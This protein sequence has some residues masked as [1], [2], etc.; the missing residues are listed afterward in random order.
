[1]TTPARRNPSNSLFSRRNA[2]CAI[3]LAASLL[4]ACG[5]SGNSLMGGGGTGA[6]A[7]GCAP[8]LLTVQDAAGDFLS[9]TVD[10]TSLKLKR[11]NG[12]DVQAIPATTRVDFAQLV[13]LSELLSA[14][15]VPYG[16]Y[17]A[18]T[19][20]VSYANAS[21]V[22]DDGNGGSVQ[23]SPVDSG[24]NPLTGSID[25]TVQ[26]PAGH[27]LMVSAGAIAHLALDF[28]LAVSNAVDL[29]NARVTVSP[30]VQASLVP[31]ATQQ[32]HVRGGL[33]SVD[34]GGAS[35]LV[36]VHPFHT[37]SDGG[38]LTVHVTDATNYEIDGTAYAGAAG[39]AALAA[40]ATGTVTA[41]YGTLD[42]ATKTFTASIVRA[43]TSV[44]GDHYDRVRGVV[45]GRSLDALKVRGATIDRDDGSFE[46]LRGNVTVNVAD[47]TQ[48]TV[49]G[50]AGTHGIG[51]ISVG[52]RISAAGTATIDASTGN[53]TLD[54]T[55]GRVRLEFTPLWGLVSGTVANP[56]T[57]SLQA[58]DGRPASIFDFSG[59]GASAAT[60]ANPSSYYAGTGTLDL[61][62]LAAGSP[63]RL[64]GFAVP[65]GTATTVDFNAAAVETI[66]S[67]RSDLD[68]SWTWPGSAQA[69]PGL[70]AASTSLA[71]DL[72][73]V[74]WAHRIRTGFERI[75]LT[76]S[77]AP[78]TPAIVADTS[79]S[80][81]MYSIAHAKSHAVDGY[82]SFADFITA[83]A[84]DM[85]G[86]TQALGLDAEGRYDATSAT[87]AARK[88]VVLLDD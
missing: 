29:V 82:A 69:F 42:V 58:I 77:G 3:L 73:G 2:A 83:L 52:Q 64:F 28:N 49:E 32:L 7:G 13:D 14:G 39:L 12:A 10:V 22:A 23:L 86:T 44:E 51:E 84:G 47:A 26:L 33:V 17:D 72:T 8:A 61:S 5:G 55:A 78:A 9:Y 68:V 11:A 85:N 66:A 38:Q 88:A 59:T 74:G 46:F 75:D 87:F 31:D 67:V 19:I 76:G 4:A 35:Y 1:M 21:I 36:D 45:I 57:L 71:L 30:A 70:T 53:A 34:S 63:V 15:Q 41:A 6:C 79:A 25:L 80:W 18:A 16:D 40:E 54:A 62:G 56:L 50:Q 27:H 81:T 60:D 24:G 20:T 37:T 65:F 48:V 43:G